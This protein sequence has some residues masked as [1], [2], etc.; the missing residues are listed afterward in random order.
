MLGTAIDQNCMILHADAAICEIW[1]ETGGSIG[2]W[3]IAGQEM[4]RRATS[5]A[6]RQP[7]PLGMG[8]FPLIPYSNRIGFGRFDWGGQTYHLEPNFHPEPHSIHGTGWTARWTAEQVA[9]DSVV[10]HYAH[11]ADKH[12]PWPFEATQH[13]M[14][15][16]DGLTIKLAAKNLSDETVPLAFGHHPYF[17]S[18]GAT[19][20][21]RADQIWQ[22]GPDG[23]PDYAEQPTGQF[24]FTNG[25]PVQGRALDNG[26]SGW[27]GKAEICWAGRP[28]ALEID[29]D[30]AAAVVYVPDGGDSFCFEPVPHLINAL[31]MPSQEPQM[32]LVLPGSTYRAQIHF[33][34]KPV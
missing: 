3:S 32:P 8:T 2:R 20:S 19:L 10:L 21:F 27:N 31:N 33:S 18:A 12:W 1:P 9:A 34:A 14:L 25:D 7:Q 28:L 11:L 17:D 5:D 30:M 24:D 13:I 22:T 16:P 4:F 15:S 6:T 26:Y 29:A 23:L